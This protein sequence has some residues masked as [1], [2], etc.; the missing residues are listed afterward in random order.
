MGLDVGNAGRDVGG[1]QIAPGDSGRHGGTA[2]EIDAPSAMRERHSLNHPVPTHPA[3]AR[4]AEEG[5][6]DR[7]RGATAPARPRV[8]RQNE[9]RRVRQRLLEHR[10]EAI[11]GDDV[12]P[13]AR[14]NHDTGGLRIRMPPLRSWTASTIS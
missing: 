1:G 2:C 10:G 9:V 3:A 6:C 13:H 4:A 11:G 7:A 12:E 5:F 8:E 14:A